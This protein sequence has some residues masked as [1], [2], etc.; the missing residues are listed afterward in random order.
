MY[1]DIKRAFTNKSPEMSKNNGHDKPHV[2]TSDF[3]PCQH[4][5]SYRVF[6]VK[7][8]KMHAAF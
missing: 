6:N 4:M 7:T 5:E 2:A 3:E 1:Q 8:T